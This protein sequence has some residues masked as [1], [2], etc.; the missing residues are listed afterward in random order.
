MARSTACS[1]A[2]STSAIIAYIVVFN[3]G[4]CQT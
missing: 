3:A 1:N 4:A 2:P